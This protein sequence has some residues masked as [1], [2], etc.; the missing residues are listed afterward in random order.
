MPVIPVYRNP[1]P[2]ELMYF[3]DTSSGKEKWFADNNFC[4]L[5]S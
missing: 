5:I 1:Y 3:L 2:D 4:R